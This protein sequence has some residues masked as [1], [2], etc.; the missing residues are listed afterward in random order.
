MDDPWV[1]SDPPGKFSDSRIVPNSFP[2]FEFALDE[3]WQ[4]PYGW[5]IADCVSTFG[6]DATPTLSSPQ[7][8]I[9]Q[10]E[11]LSQASSFPRDLQFASVSAEQPS[12][13]VVWDPFPGSFCPEPG[14]IIWN[15]NMVNGF[16]RKLS[17]DHLFANI[18]S[19]PE[20]EMEDIS[21]PALVGP[22]ISMIDHFN[23]REQE[24]SPSLLLA[25]NF[26][27]DD[28]LSS[29]LYNTQMEC[30]QLGS[31]SSNQSPQHGAQME[32]LEGNHCHWA[33][34]ES[35]FGTVLELR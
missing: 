30:L 9:I 13:P 19:F 33:V 14:D 18:S 8:Q 20:L 27:G 28:S 35:S 7:S 22:T 25:S 4:P 10:N 1:D 2:V 5:P 11:F 24:P 29:H 21:I 3:F 23:Q 15:Q 6:I 17:N 12:M 16:P 34:C 32:S 26:S 31:L